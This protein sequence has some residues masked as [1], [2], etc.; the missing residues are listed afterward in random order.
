[1]MVRCSQLIIAVFACLSFLSALAQAQGDAA[2]NPPGLT[3]L[4]RIPPS[5]EGG[6]AIKMVYYAPV[7]VDVFWRF[8]TDFGA[9]FLLSNKYIVS[10]RLIEHR[11][12]T[13]ITE[14]RYTYGGDT[15]F[16][17]KTTIDP[18]NH[19]MSYVL[20]NPQE[21]SQRFNHGTIE[22]AA[23]GNATRV[24]HV[25]YFD[26]FGALIWSYYPGPGGME[27]FLRYTARWEQETIKRLLDQY[28]KR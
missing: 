5:Q 11:N 6:R 26:F 16:R 17:W 4:Y 20:L 19:R 23:E 9:D 27:S 2:E 28:S 3:E 24:T 1:M 7:P 21:C 15:P 10:H 8:K 22:M 12:N 18:S 14:T 13:F 25:S